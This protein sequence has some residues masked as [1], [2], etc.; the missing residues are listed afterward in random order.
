[1]TFL[2]HITNYEAGPLFIVFLLGV[3]V[4]VGLARTYVTFR[5]SR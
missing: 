3:L 2:S 4:G 5:S 1:M